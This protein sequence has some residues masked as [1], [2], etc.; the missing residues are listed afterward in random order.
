M[1]QAKKILVID[2]DPDLTYGI[3]SILHVIFQPAPGLHLGNLKNY[4]YLSR[5]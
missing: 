4:L 3:Q 5:V 1:E 2:D